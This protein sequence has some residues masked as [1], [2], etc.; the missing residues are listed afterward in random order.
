MKDIGYYVYV[1]MLVSQ[2]VKICFDLTPQTLVKTLAYC[3]VPSMV[4]LCHVFFFFNVSVLY[5]ILSNLAKTSLV[6]KIVMSIFHLRY[7]L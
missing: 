6:E 4:C 2:S 1:V 5:F 3:R 7:V